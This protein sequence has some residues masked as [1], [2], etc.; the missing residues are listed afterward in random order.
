MSTTLIIYNKYLFSFS[1][2]RSTQTKHINVKLLFMVFEL[3]FFRVKLK[4]F[5]TKLL[6]IIF[7]RILYN[8]YFFLISL[9]L[10]FNPFDF[11]KK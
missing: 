11:T 7:L 9:N 3:S 8:F 2:L 1:I 10:I 6:K 5:S 4:L